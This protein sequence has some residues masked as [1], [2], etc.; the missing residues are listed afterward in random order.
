M[1]KKES[2]ENNAS[3]K[4]KDV[5]NELEKFIKVETVIG[6]PIVTGDVTII[7]L[8]DVSFG[9]GFGFNGE[10]NNDIQGGGIGGNL[11]PNS[12]LIIDGKDTK[13]ISIKDSGSVTTLI[14]QVLDKLN[15]DFIKK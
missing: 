13:L 15:F 10:T 7:P 5:L 6:K 9:M 11:S 8:V 2:K 4:I 12:V 14:P 3:E 1:A